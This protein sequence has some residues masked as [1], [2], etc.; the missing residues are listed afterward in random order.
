[1]Q[2]PPSN[3]TLELPKNH[4]NSSELID[5]TTFKAN[6]TLQPAESRFFPIGTPALIPS[7]ANLVSPFDVS[8][9]TKTLLP[10]INVNIKEK[11]K[12]FAKSFNTGADY[13]EDAIRD[14]W[15]ESPLN[16]H[17]FNKILDYKPN[18]FKHLPPHQLPPQLNGLRKPAVH[19]HHA[20][21]PHKHKEKAPKAIASFSAADELLHEYGVSGYKHFEESI[22]REIEKQE[23][24]KVEATIHTLFEHD[25]HKDRVIEII[26]GK[27]YDYK[28]GWKPVAA[29]T[30][31]Y[32][33]VVDFSSQIVSPL[34]TSIFSPV[35][36][37]GVSPQNFHDFDNLNVNSIQSAYS[38]HEEAGESKIKPVKAVRA[39]ITPIRKATQS[40]VNNSLAE[41][42]RY[43]KRHND[44]LI[45]QTKLEV[46]DM[47]D[48][49]ASGSHDAPKVVAKTKRQ[50][51]RN[52][53]QSLTTLKPKSNVTDTI[54]RTASHSH[55]LSE[56][57]SRIR[58]P[59]YRSTSASTTTKTS[60]TSTTTPKPSRNFAREASK[61][62]DKPK[63]TGYRG[64]VK[65]GQKSA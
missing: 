36:S 51:S 16:P 22:L 44:D 59:S 21:A 1:M 26:Q 11:V 10:L 6:K 61:F 39:R 5:K 57:P 29:P 20:K 15:R 17:N 27:P 33:D 49:G 7:Q 31:L 56:V 12:D 34:H 38:V 53:I 42:T 46:A 9:F 65:F 45:I 14:S 4:K 62:V 55:K 8:S 32:D 23:E 19:H 3:A 58:L 30:K 25:K 41:K 37:Q 54:S 18:L 47:A 50:P 52:H 24:L 35:E 43:H 13:V 40:P 60:S 64:S 63:V 2:S 48:S 28:A